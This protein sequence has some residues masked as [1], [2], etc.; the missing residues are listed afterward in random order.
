LPET[1]ES[2]FAVTSIETDA[3]LAS[4]LAQ[5]QPH[6]IVTCGS[7]FDFP[8]LLAMPLEV[9]R[10]WVHMRGDPEP[11]AT[12][13]WQLLNAYVDVATRNR[14]PLEPLVSVF[15]PTYNTSEA[16]RRPYASLLEQRYTNWE[17]VIYDDSPDTATFDILADLAATDQR[18]RLFRST[19]NSGVIG[20]VKRRCTGLARGSIL[21]ELDH[22]DQ[23]LANCLG[24]VVEAFQRF[25]DAGFAYSDCAEVFD[26]GENG[27]YGD[28][29]AFGCGSYRSETVAGRTYLATN[30]PSINSKTVRHI[31]GMPNH[32]RAWTREGLAA[33]GGYASEVHV[34]DDYELLIRTFLRT[35]MV[36]IRR[37]G[38]VQW[39]SR[40]QSN[41]QRQRNGE[42]QRL[43]ALFAQRYD[44]EIHQRF[45]DLGVD[46]FIWTPEGLDW[47][48]PLPDPLPIANYVLD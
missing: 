9:R 7:E 12:A 37:F 32:V 26:D 5:R 18:I 44:A 10:R 31:V 17:W 19:G 43:T 48:R 33:A 14:F 21:V 24:D 35:R 30:Y 29:F 27:W 34:A 4:A 23:L 6:L 1:W 25:P 11:P 36:H 46:D 13:A 3:T 16:I 28:T 47:S 40:A 20:E 38:Y 42:I 8:S 41:T 45:E 2:S 15:T 39:I 22:D